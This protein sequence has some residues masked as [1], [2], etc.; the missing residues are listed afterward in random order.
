MEASARAASRCFMFMYFL[1]HH[2]VSVTWRSLAQ[3]SIRAELSSGK[4]ATTRVQRRVSKFSF[5]TTLLVRIQVQC[6]LRNHDVMLKNVKCAAEGIFTML[7]RVRLAGLN[8]GK[9]LVLAIQNNKGNIHSP[10]LR[11]W[12]CRAF[13]TAAPRRSSR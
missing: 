2:W 9:R 13:L 6:F 7:T 11:W 3:T 5:S 10:I 8:R 12:T 4:L 1:F